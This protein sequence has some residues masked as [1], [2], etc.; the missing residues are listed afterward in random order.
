M[1]KIRVWGSR[2]SIC[3]PGPQ[4]IRY[5]GNTACVEVQTGAGKTIVLDAG[6]GLR[7]FG[8]ELLRVKWTKEVTLLFTHAH[9]D[10]LMGFPFF[11]PA[12]LPGYTI[13]L[14]G[15]PMAQDTIRKYLTRQME[16]PFFPVDFSI[17]RAKFLFGC[18][19]QNGQCP[20][21]LDAAANQQCNA[22]PLSHPNGGFGYS[23]SEQGRKF[24]FLTDNELGV[25]H[26][27]SASRDE[28]VEFCRGA[29][30]LFHDAQYTEKEYRVTRG[31]GHSTFAEAV[32]LALDAGVRR[33]G[34]YHHDPDRTDDALDEQVAFC[35]ARIKQRGSDMECFAVGE[36]MTFEV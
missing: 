1:M 34:L 16:P 12:Y 20:G 29:D 27:G 18:H 15:G 5:G 24:V 26:A 25:A 4:T 10:H 3:A 31:W 13:T 28:Y 35:Q 14:S 8:K 30:L 36:G 22:I 23:F 21:T 19:C 6:S 33:L 32:D 9:W 11:T 7:L 17:M 2:G